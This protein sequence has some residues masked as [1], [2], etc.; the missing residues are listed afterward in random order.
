MALFLDTMPTIGNEYDT[1]PSSLHMM[2]HV[3]RGRHHFDIVKSISNTDTALLLTQHM[4]SQCVEGVNCDKSFMVSPKVGH[5]QHYRVNCPLG[6]N[7][8]DKN[9][10]NL[11]LEEYIVKDTGVWKHL[12]TVVKNTNSALKNISL[13]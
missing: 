12:E 4:V 3:Y 11:K 9:C 7:Y 13:I 10:E 8:G 1:V 5:N 2:Q 6:R